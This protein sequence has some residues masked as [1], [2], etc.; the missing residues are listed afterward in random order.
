MAD[1]SSK[2]WHESICPTNRL[3]YLWSYRG[4]FYSGTSW[5]TLTE[6]EMMQYNAK[7]IADQ[8]YNPW[9]GGKY[10]T[11]KEQKGWTLLAIAGAFGNFQA[12]CTMNPALIERSYADPDTGGGMG[13]AQWTPNKRFRAWMDEH[14]FDYYSIVG[15]AAFMA[16]E[17]CG[18]KPMGEAEWLEYWKYSFYEYTQIADETPE[19]AA[20]IFGQNYERPAAGEY[21]QRQNNAAKWYEW[22]LENPPTLHQNYESMRKSNLIYY[23]KRRKHVWP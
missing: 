5:G 16:D 4:Y 19:R 2:E 23:M 11:L 3:P 22:L 8:L 18:G 6:T 9:W 13:L 21:E 10:N 20:L 15:Q 14:G 17:M 12:E 1:L 7:C